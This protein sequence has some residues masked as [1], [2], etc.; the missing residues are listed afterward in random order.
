[1]TQRT[2]GLLVFLTLLAT[3]GTARAHLLPRPLQL[4]CLNAKIAGHVVDYTANH[5]KDYRNYSPALGEKRDLY[6]YLPPG[7]DPN[8]RYPL[9]IYLHGFLADEF[10]FLDDVVKPFDAAI[11]RGE[12]PPMILAAPDGSPRGLDCIT[13]AGTFYVNSKLGCFEDYLVRDVYD[14][15]MN[16]YPIRPEPEAHLLLGVSMGGASAFAKVMKF[17]DKFGLAATFAPPLN[18]RW[19]SCRGKYFDNFDPS[20]WDY[21]TDYSNGRDVVG[22]FLGGL[23]KVRLRTFI[24]PMYGKDNP[25]TAELVARENPLELLDFLDVKPGFAE[26]YVAYGGKDQFNLDAQI[27]SFLYRAKEKGIEIAVDYLPDGKH[28]AKT[29]LKMLPPMLAWLKPR[30]EPYSPQ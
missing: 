12:L 11:A 8:K 19:I 24:H 17:R 23:V 3:G 26:F 15:L 14:F 30:L 10:S 28:D 20:C 29:A 25:H 7:F 6:V 16:N 13:S 5:G 4:R 1:M 27:D 9:A 22:R 2:T 21:R 18:T